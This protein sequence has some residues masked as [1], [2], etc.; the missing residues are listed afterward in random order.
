M[1]SN[2]F[3]CF[4]LEK[5]EFAIPLI[6]VREVIGVPEITPIPQ[7]PSYLLGIMNLR[8]QV[9][10]VMDLRLKLGIKNARTEETAVIILDLGD[11]HLGVMVDQVN[12]VVELNDSDVSEKPPVDSSKIAE[13]I[14][15]VF[16]KQDKLILMLDVYKSLSLE[17]RKSIKNE[18]K[19]A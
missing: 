1:S 16:R 14:T 5:E 3:L 17:D 6:S 4:N 19:V 18:I 8:G 7:S 13:A 11:Y 10:T 15:G 9:L 2:R 12:S